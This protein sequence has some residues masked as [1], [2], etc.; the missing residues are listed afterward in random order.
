MAKF[1]VVTPKLPD[2]IPDLTG[3]SFELEME[4]L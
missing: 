1:K 4:A 3:P 2:K